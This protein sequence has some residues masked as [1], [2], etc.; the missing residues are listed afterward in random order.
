MLA[1]SIVGI[2]IQLGH[3]VNFRPMISAAIAP[4]ANCPAAPILKR[5]ARKAIATE[6]LAK[7]SG[8]TLTNVS[9]ILE[10][11]PY[12]PVKRA[13]YA[14]TMSVKGSTVLSGRVIRITMAPAIIDRI[15]A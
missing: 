3:D 2:N 7:M 8:D 12:E 1:S 11:D 13:E 14:W 6:I 5:P 9:E 10:R 15:T 4:T